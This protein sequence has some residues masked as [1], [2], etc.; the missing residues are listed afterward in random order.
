MCCSIDCLVW[1]SFASVERKVKFSSRNSRGGTM[2]WR[3]ISRALRRVSSSAVW[4]WRRFW[5]R[6][7][8]KPTWR[9]FLCRVR[10]RCRLKRPWVAS[11]TQC[12]LGPFSLLFLHLYGLCLLFFVMTESNYRGIQ[13]RFAPYGGVCAGGEKVCPSSRT[14]TRWTW[15]APVVTDV[16]S[17]VKFQKF[18]IKIHNQSQ[19]LNDPPRKLWEC[20]KS[21]AAK[22]KE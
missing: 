20:K 6:I 10:V 1:F 8:S 15:R 16:H 9:R 2:W 18:N 14:R 17:S 11:E 5:R 7:K 12:L 4:I 21:K 22:A 3:W 13:R 19:S